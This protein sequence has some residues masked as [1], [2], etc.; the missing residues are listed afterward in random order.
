MFR[1]YGTDCCLVTA[2]RKHFQH[3]LMFSRFDYQLKIVQEKVS[4]F[5]ALLW[6]DDSRIRKRKLRFQCFVSRCHLRRM[7]LAKI[8]S[9]LPFP[10]NVIAGWSLQPAPDC[11]TATLDV[12]EIEALLSLGEK[13]MREGTGA[14][15]VTTLLYAP[16]TQY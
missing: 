2:T 8:I 15:E 1:G 9:K 10:N 13:Q 3:L 11:K 5:L 4:L 14:Y 7:I 12:D 16:Y 6:Y